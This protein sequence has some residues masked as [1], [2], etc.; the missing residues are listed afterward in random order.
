MGSLLKGRRFLIKFDENGYLWRLNQET[1]L[2]MFK[3]IKSLTPSVSALI[4]LSFF[5][6]TLTWGSSFILVKRGLEAYSSWQVA[7]LRLVSAFAVLG[8][9]GAMALKHIPVRKLPIIFVSS[10]LSMF[11]PAYLFSAAQIGVSSSVAGVLNALT[12]VFTFIMGILLFRQPAKL[13]QIL[14]LSLGFMGS[15]VL[16]LRNKQGDFALNGYAL[17][18]VVAT[19]CYGFNV[20]LVKKYTLHDNFFEFKE[21]V[22]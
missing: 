7:S 12:P 1:R 14:G 13:L 2:F 9:F 18:V 3:N 22:M 6:L 10:M 8:V 20:N 15:A 4:W 21:V 5:V 11:V 16:I 17:C 19:I